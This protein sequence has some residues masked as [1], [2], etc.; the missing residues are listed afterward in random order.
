[1]KQ[2][3][4]ASKERMV[5][6]KEGKVPADGKWHDIVAG[7]T[8]CHA[9]EIMAYSGV[10][11]KGKYALMHAIAISTFGKSKS[12]ISKTCAHYGFWWNKITLR[13]VGETKNFGLQIKT[14]SNYGEG[15]EI[16]FRISLLWDSSIM[17]DIK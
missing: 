12:K 5:T 8:G 13:W 14:M 4:V 6:N 3:H 16:Y 2:G 10:E 9:F 11:G 7:L 1:M 17:K 15:N